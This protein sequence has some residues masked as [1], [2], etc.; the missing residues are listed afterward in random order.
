VPI[1]REAEAAGFR[2]VYRDVTGS[3]NDDAVAALR[4]GDR[5]KLWSVAGAQ[6]QGRGRH[7]RVWASPAGNLYASLLLV[8]PCEMRYAAQLGYLVGLSLHDA[9]AELAPDHVRNV[10]LKWPNDVLFDGA[11][12]AGIL[13]EGHRAPDGTFALVVGIGVNVTDSPSDA[14]YPTSRIAAFAPQLDRKTLFEALSRALALRYTRWR[15]AEDA[16]FALAQLRKEWITRAAGLDQTVTI[17]LPSGPREGI[18]TGLDNEGRL[19]LATGTGIVTIDAGDLFFP[20]QAAPTPA[21]AA[22]DDIED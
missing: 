9:I 16:D 18:F 17:R 2:L 14:P 3:T 1:A 5:G 12:I 22:R 13:L 19:L 10:K 6:M 15:A 21:R 11:K 4:A 20:D 7:G 8:D